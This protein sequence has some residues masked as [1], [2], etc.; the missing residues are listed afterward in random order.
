MSSLAKL[1]IV[2]ISM[3]LTV[4]IGTIA[5]WLKASY[6]ELKHIS[7]NLNSLQTVVSGLQVQ[8][9]KSI[10]KDIAEV[11]SDINSLYT[12]TNKLESLIHAKVGL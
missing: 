10:E 9:E 5:Y 8:I 12:K 3:L 7:N 11:K 6:T 2:I 1:D 4:L